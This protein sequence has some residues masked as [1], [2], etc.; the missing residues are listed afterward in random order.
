MMTKNTADLTLWLLATIMLKENTILAKVTPE[1]PPA[2]KNV[3]HPPE[4]NINPTKFME[5]VL[6]PSPVLQEL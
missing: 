5:K 4:E 1:P 2:K 6:T 3:A